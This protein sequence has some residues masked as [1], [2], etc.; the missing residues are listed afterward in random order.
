MSQTNQNQS[1]NEIDLHLGRYE[2]FFKQRYTIL[3]NVNDVLIGLWFLIGSIF[4]YW[5]AT[6]IWGTTLF[7]LGSAQLLIRPLIRIV[8]RVHFKRVQKDNSLQ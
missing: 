7:V 4:F 3:Y 1:K 6:K 8:H 2:V 5:E